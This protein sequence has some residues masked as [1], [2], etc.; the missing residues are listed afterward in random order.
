MKRQLV[1]IGQSQLERC[2]V[3]LAE[4]K[5][6]SIA[7]I[8]VLDGKPKTYSGIVIAVEERIGG[9]QGEFRVTIDTV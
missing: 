3:S 6:E 9:E 5:R 4:R 1:C 8:D 7:G 2:K